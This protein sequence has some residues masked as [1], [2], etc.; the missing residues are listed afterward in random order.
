VGI[1]RGESIDSKLDELFYHIPLPI[2]FGHPDGKVQSIFVI[3]RSK[4]SS[5]IIHPNGFFIDSL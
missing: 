5:L 4:G 1:D 3:A 2:P